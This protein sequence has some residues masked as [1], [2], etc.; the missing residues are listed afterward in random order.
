MTIKNNFDIIKTLIF[1][2]IKIQINLLIFI[3]F[4]PSMLD[5]IILMLFKIYI[6]QNLI[7]SQFIAINILSLAYEIPE[8]ISEIILLDTKFKIKGKQKE[9]IKNQKLSTL[10]LISFVS[11]INQL[12]NF[13]IIIV[14]YLYYNFNYLQ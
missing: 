4:I 5:G 3:Y 2:M 10:I 14:K 8:I 9:K 11:S 1:E 6:T 7:A 12:Q 13:P